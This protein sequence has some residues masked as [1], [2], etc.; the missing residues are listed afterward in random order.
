[1]F[2]LQYNFH[3]ENGD[4]I[5]SR[6]DRSLIYNKFSVAVL[7]SQGNR[8]ELAEPPSLTIFKVNCLIPQPGDFDPPI[9]PVVKDGI[10][11]W[12]L[13]FYIGGGNN[14]DPNYALRITAKGHAEELIPVRVYSNTNIRFRKKRIRMCYN[15]SNCSC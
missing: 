8:V 13:V 10:Y 5:T 3:P 14:S 7:D 9:G 2:Q 1:M 6:H 12:G 4:W 11:L 15:M